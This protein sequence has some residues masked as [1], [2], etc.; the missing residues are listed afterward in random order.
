M[1]IKIL[2]KSGVQTYREGSGG[3]WPR[4]GVWGCAALNIPFS[5]LS[6]SSQ[7]SHFKQNVSSQDSL[8]RKF[9]NFSLYSLN[10]WTNFSSKNPQIWKFSAHKPPLSE[11]SI[12]SQASHFGNPGRTPLPEKKK[13]ECPS[14]EGQVVKTNHKLH[15]RRQQI[16]NLRNNNN[17]RKQIHVKT[18]EQQLFDQIKSLSTRKYKEN[19][20]IGYWK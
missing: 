11:A 18:N 3:H 4:K 16:K 7:G 2:E 13:V 17:N 14:E 12:S 8:L 6:C 5:R 20:E 9:G 15:I 10:F 1:P 19:W